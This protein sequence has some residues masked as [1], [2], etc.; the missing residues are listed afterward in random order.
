M[1]II[2][3]DCLDVMK[4]YPE[5]YFSGIVTDPPYGLGFMGK[6][7]DF[8]LPCAAIWAEML[9]VCKPGSIM[10]CFGGTRT[11]HHLACA[12]ENLGWKIRD[13]IIWLYGS[14]F[15]KSHNFGRAIGGK[16]TGYGTAL[17]PAWEPII[18]AMKPLD[19]TFEQNAKKWG[20]A[21]LNIDVSRIETDVDLGRNNPKNSK[22]SPFW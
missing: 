20:V 7:W 13:T 9:R 3:G 11:W 17:K 19:G 16:W 5:N 22:V 10:L 8:G 12:M 21:G 14:G 6:E 15:P 1:E 2:Q 4:T 18:V